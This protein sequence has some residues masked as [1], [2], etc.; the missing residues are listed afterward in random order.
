MISLE[1]EKLLSE[2]EQKI[3]YS[4]RSRALRDDHDLGGGGRRVQDHHLGRRGRALQLAVEGADV[5]GD[6]LML[7]RQ[8][9]AELGRAE[10]QVHRRAVIC[11]LNRVRRVRSKCL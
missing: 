7:A 10:R 6:L 8:A 5:D 4:F 9:G 3:G 1:R 2:L 11:N